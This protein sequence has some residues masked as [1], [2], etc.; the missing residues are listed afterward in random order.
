MTGSNRLLLGLGWPFVV[1]PLFHEE[2]LAGLPVDHQVFRLDVAVDHA[3]LVRRLERLRGLEE[4]PPRLGHRDAALPRQHGLERFAP[5]QRHQEP[6]DAVGLPDVVDRDDMRILERRHRLR[7]AAEACDQGVGE[8]EVG[9]DDLEG[10]LPLQTEV[11]DREHLGVPAAADQPPEL[12]GRAQRGPQPLG[13]QLVTGGGAARRATGAQQGLAQHGRGGG[14]AADGAERGIGRDRAL[15]G[16][17]GAVTN[18]AS[19]PPSARRGGPGRP[20][21]S[22]RGRPGSPIF[23][24]LCP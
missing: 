19:P 18:G 21:S 17:T 7:L 1:G 12:V 2:D 3:R 13:G 14:Y 11:A 20:P 15:A 24:R 5:D 8:D 9:A 23:P 6:A 16:G 22:A 4:D 10:E